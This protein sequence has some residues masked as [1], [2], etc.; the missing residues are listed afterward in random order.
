MTTSL[1]TRGARNHV[2]NRDTYQRQTAPLQSPG[3]KPLKRPGTAALMDPAGLKAAV[4]G[5][6]A[7]GSQTIQNLEQRVELLI[8][9]CQAAR[10]PMPG[11]TVDVFKHPMSPKSDQ[12]ISYLT[13]VLKSNQNLG[14]AVPVVVFRYQDAVK[15]SNAAANAVMM[16]TLQ[17]AILEE[18]RL[19]LFYLSRFHEEFKGDPVLS[20]LFPPPQTATSTIAKPGTAPLSMADRLKA[21]QAQ[22]AV[23]HKAE[24]LAAN[25]EPKMEVIK[26]VVE[27][28][29]ST[30]G[31]N[32][33]AM[34]TPATRQARMIA[35][36]I[37]SN[38]ALVDQLKQAF[39]LHQQLQEA[40]KEAR[41]SGEVEPLKEIAY[42][43]SQL[44]H[45]CRQ[46]PML[47]D[48]FPPAE[49]DMF[50][51]PEGGGGDLTER[52]QVPR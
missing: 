9:A 27:N 51:A 14:R 23:L 49:E 3:T 4:E 47:K 12:I 50:P 21:K 20:Q 36:T 17:S 37:G 19:K 2:Q 11:V 7:K 5:L 45:T 31:L 15:V 52:P 8:R 43:L 44:A 16:N 18:L 48:L 42:P 33:G 25:L 1:S 26:A 13:E 39:A 10:V 46:Q 35:M 32:L 38:K 6:L 30:K 22:Q 29:E 40:L 24:I 41:K 28:L 34:F